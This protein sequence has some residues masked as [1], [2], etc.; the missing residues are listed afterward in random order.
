M[1]EEKSKKKKKIKLSPNI[2]NFYK[3]FERKGIITK[4]QH[5]IGTEFVIDDNFEINE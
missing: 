4:P 1:A 3:K 2:I 5:I